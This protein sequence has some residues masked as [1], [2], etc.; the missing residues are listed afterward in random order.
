MPEPSPPRLALASRLP[1]FYGWLIVPVAMVVHICT[2]PG[3]TYGISVFIPHLREAL[4]LSQSGL[5]GAYMLG[6]LLASLPMTY[7]GHL[8]DRYGPRRAL[9]GVV[10]L[11]GLTCLGM[12]Q[13]RGLLSLFAAF[14]FL[15]MLGQGAM[16]LLANGAVAMWF[17]RKLGTVSGIMSVGM[18]AALGGIPALNVFLIGRLGWRLTYALLGVAVWTLVLPLVGL[19][20]RDKP[21][22][23]GQRLDGGARAGR[24]DETEEAGHPP[25]DSY[26][27]LSAALRTRAYWIVAGATAFWS[28]TVTGVHFH[29]MQIFL[30]RGLGETDAAAMFT[31]FAAALA[32]TRFAGGV[33]ADRIPLNVLLAAGMAGMATGFVLLTRLSTPTSAHLFAASLGASAGIH[34]AVNATVWVRYYGRPHLGKIIGSMATVGIGASSLGPFLMGA[35]HDLFGRYDE[36]VWLFAAIAVPLTVL[37]LLAT[38]PRRVVSRPPVSSGEAAGDG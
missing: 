5:S 30:D 16:G 24:A 27:S 28:M 17:N 38:K 4:G 25:R 10:V 7:V 1:F 35:A 21:E 31:V 13:V 20:L 36:S 37:S 34:M 19:L 32:V 6:T 14:F 23:V 29:S 15:R 18:A 22:E 9:M 12:T 26:Y 2:S 8:M 3:Q 33:L 11:F